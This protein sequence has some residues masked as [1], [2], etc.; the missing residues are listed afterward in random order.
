MGWLRGVW[1]VGLALFRD[2]AV[3]PVGVQ[4]AHLRHVLQL[5]LHTHTHR[6]AAQGLSWSGRRCDTSVPQ[7]SVGVGWWVRTS[8]TGA[9]P[10]TCPVVQSP[11]K[12]M[13]VMAV[14]SVCP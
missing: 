14:V 3:G 8:H 11:G 9:M 12:V 2:G 1:R 10:P 13:L 5:E 4:V 6:Q 7:G